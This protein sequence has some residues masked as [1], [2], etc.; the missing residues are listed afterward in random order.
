MPDII[1]IAQERAAEMLAHQIAAA[2]PKS[3]AV[4]CTFCES[5]E[6]PIPEARRRAIQG[7]EL[8]VTCQEIKERKS[9]HFKG[10]AK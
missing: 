1:D 7:V 8:C 10:G 5:C 4:G 3:A 9:A 6:A 2:R